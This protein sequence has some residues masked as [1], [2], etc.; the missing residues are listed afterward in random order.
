[1]DFL[2]LDNFDTC[3]TSSNFTS[4][5]QLNKWNS[6]KTFIEC[7]RKLDCSYL[8]LGECATIVATNFLVGVIEGRGNLSCL[9]V[10]C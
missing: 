2:N 1:M 9:Q 7:A 6:Y 4:Q 3:K 8:M 5:E 10:V